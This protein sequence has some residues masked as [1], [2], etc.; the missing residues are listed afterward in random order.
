MNK[1]LRKIGNALTGRRGIGSS[2][3]V[4]LIIAVVLLNMI[5]YTVTDAFGLYLYSPDR[6]DLSISGNTD[7][8]YRDA[9]T[10]GKK[11]KITFMMSEASLE[12]HDTG[13]FVLETAR[14]FEERYPEFIE[15]HF[16]NML[17]K[18]DENMEI[19][20]FDTYTKDGKYNFKTTSV[21]FE[22]GEGASHSFRVLTDNTTSVGFV[23][24]YTL[25]SS[26]NIQAYCGEEVVAAMISWVLHDEHPTAYLTQNHGETAD[27]AF[28]NLLTCAGYYVNVINL[29][30]DEVPSDAGLVIISNP[31]SDFEK[32][33][34]GSE[35]RGEIDRLRSYLERG[36]SLY[37]A[38]DPYVKK[39]NNLEALIS[40]YGI[41]LSGG[42]NENGIYI[43]DIVKESGE[44]ITADGFTFVATHAQGDIS[45]EIL[46]KVERFG[47]DRV[48]MSNVARLELDPSLGAEPLLITSG[49][50]S[51]YRGGTRVDSD[52]GYT[53]SAY[54]ERQH[55]NGE[56]SRVFVI[57]TAY[58]T[59][60]DAFI[61]EGY[62][63]K[64]FIYAT[65]EVIFGS[66]PAPYGCNQLL[67]GTTILENFTMGRARIYTAIILAIP[68]ILAAIG[69]VTIVR[70]RNR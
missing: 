18:L 16:V 59:A 46:S 67:Y 68:A 37:V 64:D 27:L 33:I 39:L 9:M 60:S 15:L 70:R 53:V 20:D 69:A 14:A 66:H 38:L 4:V 7:S 58:I 6:S 55:E 42:E 31:T 30:R 8:M 63:N 22:T 35:T 1:F 5:A 41:T 62:S 40:E 57:P 2:M 19:F 49:G 21:L 51:L 23:D 10:L 11:V 29:R 61:S 56:T 44:A 12:K 52:G 3:T 47:Q 24:F 13:S 26:M 32:G 36:G 48:L 50:A 45:S 34:E 25:D 43:K 65:L 54:S 17:T 28:S